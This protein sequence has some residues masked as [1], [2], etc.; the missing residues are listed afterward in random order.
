VRCGGLAG[1]THQ[2]PTKEKRDPVALTTLDRVPALVVIDLQKGL[3]TI[4]TVHPIEQVVDRA[5]RLAGAFRQHLLPVIL[6]NATGRAPG[7]TEADRTRNSDSTP[8]PADWADLVDELDVQ[9][10]DHLV[11]K[12][13]WGAFHDTSLDARLRELGVTQVV[14]AGVST[15]A[16]VES[17]ARSAYEHGYNV[18]LATD[19]MTDR[20][21]AAHENSVER[22]FPK[23]GETAT[24]DEILGFLNGGTR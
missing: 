7:R 9:P 6:V 1:P 17:T 15:S 10:E 2:L 16:G 14:L 4:P 3:M 21:P 12:Q 5:A 23:L 8:P 11:T 13:R 19:A 18:V 24:T 20:D 22:I